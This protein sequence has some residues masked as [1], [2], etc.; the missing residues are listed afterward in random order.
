MEEEVEIVNVNIS[1]ES[2]SVWDAENW[3][4]YWRRI[5]AHRIVLKTGGIRIWQNDQWRAEIMVQVRNPR[6]NK[7]NYILG[8]TQN[9]IS[10]WYQQ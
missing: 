2:L 7:D 9:E 3:E 8:G 4:V 10:C 1:Y 6:M 5:G